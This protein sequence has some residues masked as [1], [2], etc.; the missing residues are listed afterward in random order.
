MTSEKRR[1]VYVRRLVLEIALDHWVDSKVLNE[2]IRD[3]LIPT[4][5]VGTPNPMCKNILEVQITNVKSIPTP[6]Y[7]ELSDNNGRP[8]NGTHD[9][10]HGPLDKEPH[11]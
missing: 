11:D 7:I 10:L 5:T 2:H 1:K 3:C 9:S 4:Y 8:S 6:R